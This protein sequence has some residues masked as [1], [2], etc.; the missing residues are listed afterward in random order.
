MKPVN[1]LCAMTQ[2]LIE[3]GVSPADAAAGLVR[4]GWTQA[5]ADASV[6]IYAPPPPPPPAA[7]PYIS[8]MQRLIPAVSSNFARNLLEQQ[9]ATYRRRRKAASPWPRL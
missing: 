4:L 2:A 3:S 5:D 9:L 6:A 1:N 8:C 7:D